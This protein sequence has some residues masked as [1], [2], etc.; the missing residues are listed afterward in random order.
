MILLRWLELSI[1]AEILLTGDKNKK[2]SRQTNERYH[3]ISYIKRTKNDYR[4]NFLDC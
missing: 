2:K 3:G 4:N 1:C